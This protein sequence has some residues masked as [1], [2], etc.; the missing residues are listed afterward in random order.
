MGLMNNRLLVE[1]ILERL[2]SI[3]APTVSLKVK[4]LTASFF[5]NTFLLTFLPNTVLSNPNDERRA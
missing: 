5:P 2:N 1:I 3:L 4:P